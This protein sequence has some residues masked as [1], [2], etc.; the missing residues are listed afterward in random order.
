MHVRRW[1]RSIDGDGYWQW[2]VSRDYPDASVCYLTADHP[3]LPGW[4]VELAA[5]AADPASDLF[6]DDQRSALWR[7]PEGFLRSESGDRALV[8][9][10]GVLQ[11]HRSYGLG[12]ER[13]CVI[14]ADLDADLELLIAFEI[15]DM[16]PHDAPFDEADDGCLV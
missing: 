16:Q 1:R 5:Y 2:C 14:V 8:C 12:H 7:D 13:Y 15:W 10:H 11:W 4:Q 9:E 3:L 6:D